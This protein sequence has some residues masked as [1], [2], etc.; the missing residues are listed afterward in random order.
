MR[1]EPVEEEHRS[2]K[3]LLEIVSSKEKQ[4]TSS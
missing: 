3:G 4:K 2:W 1:H